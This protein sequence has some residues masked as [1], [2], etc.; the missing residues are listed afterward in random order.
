MLKVLLFFFCTL[1][2]F[3][4]DKFEISGRD[5]DVNDNIVVSEEGAVLLHEGKYLYAKKVI[6]DNAKKEATLLGD[7]V[8]IDNNNVVLGSEKAIVNLASDETVFV[9]FFLIDDE[10][11]LW[12]KSDEGEGKEKLYFTKKAL[13]S[14]C[15]PDNPDWVIR[16]SSM[17]YDSNAK[18]LDLYNPVIYIK[19][20]PVFYFPYL[21]LSTNKERKSGL[22]RPTIGIGGDDGFM[23]EQP[24]FIAPSLWWDL[25]LN[26]QIRTNRSQGLYG[27]LRFVNGAD[28]EG[29]LRIGNFET[30]ESY[31]KEHDLEKSSHYGVEFYYD[32]ANIFD[33]VED[34]FYFNGKYVS[35]I[36][37]FD[38]TSKEE[39]S[40]NTVGDKIESK[41]N[42]YV[43]DE[44]FYF[45]SY[46]KY[47]KDTSKESNKNTLQL[48]PKTQL[49]KFSNSLLSDNILYSVDLS[50]SNYTRREGVRAQ[51]TEFSLPLTFHTQLFGDY[52]NFSITEQMYATHVDFTRD[53]RSYQYRNLVH[54]I[55][56][57]TDLIKAYQNGY[58]NINFGISYT[59]PEY[60][61]EA[62]KYDALTA[63][64]KEFFSVTVPSRGFNIYLKQYFYDT[65]E[66]EI[67]YHKF[68]QT[69]TY[70]DL[71]I[72]SAGEM[73][74]SFRFSMFEDMSINL[75]T[76]YNHD[77]A[78]FSRII[79]SFRL[80]K[81]LYDMT[82]RHLYTNEFNGNRSS[83][84]TL[85]AGYNFFPYRIYTSIDYD[86]TNR[87]VKKK[88]LGLRMKKRCWD[89]AITFSEDVTPTLTSKSKNSK[90]DR[91][92]MF[93][94]N[95]VPLGGFAQSLL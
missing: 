77:E 19:D 74:N 50:H 12:I 4:Q 84:V 86:Y 2:L 82:I 5:F 78:D 67:F 7:V 93:E 22:L 75:R 63:V 45:G 36:D 11:K 29:S 44:S 32:D 26:P 61:K 73:E 64:Q 69:F 18:L 1:F 49:H 94:I 17:E 34:G 25:E 89:Y 37:Y 47:Y 48:L 95:L 65:Q 56:L 38:L 85:G 66:R 70:N 57:Y 79:T 8:I 40:A 81:E 51:Q 71:G 62:L 80:K 43:K 59:Y 52:L 23:Y 53:Y 76:F 15:D 35:D 13:T 90:K 68:N 54:K 27:T 20:T 72:R 58:H 21:K 28:S 14:S 41:M 91:R 16:F 31:K 83:Y 88:T 55:D 24:I 6:Y 39:V 10:S 3:A 92:L 87:Y 46:S 9:P 33:G 42:Y 30:K 60:E